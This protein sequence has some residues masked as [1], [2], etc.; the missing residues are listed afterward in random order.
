MTRTSKNQDTLFDRVVS[1]LEQARSNVVRSVNSNM[2]I[3]YWMIG[4]EIVEAVQGGEERAVYGRQIIEGLSMGLT[5]K[6]GKGFSVTN[7]QYFRKFYQTYPDRLGIQHPL[8]AESLKSDFHPEISRPTGVELTFAEKNSPA[9]IE[10]K[11]GFHSSLSW[12][13]YR[14]LMRVNN[15]EARSFYEIEAAECGWS[16]AQLERQIHTSYYERI[17]K[18][19]GKKGLLPANR[20]QLPGDALSPVHILKAPYVLE[21]LDLPDSH[22]LHEDE[23]EQTIINNLQSFLLELGKGFSFVA[24]QKHIRYDDDNFYVDLVFYNFILKCFLL[25]DLSFMQR[26]KGLLCYQERISRVQAEALTQRSTRT[27]KSTVTL[28]FCEPVISLLRIILIL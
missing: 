20:E 8:G 13:H 18:N 23:L 26:I 2:V 9:C 3:V 17:L 24:R 11:N 4:R 19:K 10:S 7:L 12:S 21:F 16:K 14:A 28:R 1:I 27:R 25:I 22:T 5:K 6:Y 15:N